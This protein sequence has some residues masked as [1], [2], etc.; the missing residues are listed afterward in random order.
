MEQTFALLQASANKGHVTCCD[1]PNL[2]FASSPYSESFLVIFEKKK[3]KKPN[4]VVLPE[5][6]EADRRMFL[7]IKV[8][9]ATLRQE[10][11]QEPLELLNFLLQKKK[12]K[13]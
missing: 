13:R 12:K 4:I 10:T 11:F 2:Q 8:C 7:C 5:E 1:E 3:K 9:W 6:R